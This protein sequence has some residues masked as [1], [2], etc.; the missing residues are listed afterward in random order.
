[1]DGKK[2]LKYIVIGVIAGFVI[3][4]FVSESGP[5]CMN[6]I[7]FGLLL[8]IALYWFSRK[9]NTTEE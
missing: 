6:L 5:D 7:K 9:T 2:L 1:M 4:E 3:M 8:V